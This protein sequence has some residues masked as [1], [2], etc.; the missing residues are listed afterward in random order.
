MVVSVLSSVGLLQSKG[1]F[2]V[3]LQ[4]GFSELS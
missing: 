3:L 4:G 2:L 1:R